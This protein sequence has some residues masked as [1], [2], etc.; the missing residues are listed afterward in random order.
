[1][2]FNRRLLFFYGYCQQNVFIQKTF[3]LLTISI[4][5]FSHNC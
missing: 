5:H 4:E 2:P 3:L 1:M